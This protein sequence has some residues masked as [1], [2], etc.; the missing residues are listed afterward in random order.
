MNR[1]QVYLPKS[2]LDALRRVARERSETV[3][4]VIRALIR[5]NGE[6]SPARRAPQG[7]SRTLFTVLEEIKKSGERGPR[8]LAENMDKYLYGE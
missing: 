1:T 7:A 4:E 2:Q 5:R 8:D 3:S 6:A